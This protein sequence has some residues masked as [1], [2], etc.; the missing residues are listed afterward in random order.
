MMGPVITH[1]DV[2]LKLK[3]FSF[4]CVHFLTIVV[5]TTVDL[6]SSIWVWVSGKRR[7]ID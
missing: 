4:R 1:K 5:L 2:Y 6:M 7:P 3:S